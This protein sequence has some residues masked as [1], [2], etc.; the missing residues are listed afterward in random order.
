MW[1]EQYVKRA[2]VTNVLPTDPISQPDPSV[3]GNSINS[4]APSERAQRN[5]MT[6][7]PLL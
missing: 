4:A 6:I 3:E 2:R 5:Y 7:C 1:Y